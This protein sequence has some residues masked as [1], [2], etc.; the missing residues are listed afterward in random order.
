[1]TTEQQ[2]QAVEHALDGHHELIAKAREL[3]GAYALEQ[4]APVGSELG[5]SSQIRRRLDELEKVL[6][7]DFINRIMAEESVY[8][9]GMLQRYRRIRRAKP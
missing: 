7:Q 5:Y 1:M 2:I 8:I 4:K 6:G 3:A 9:A